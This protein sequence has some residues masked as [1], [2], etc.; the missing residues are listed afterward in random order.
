VFI[1]FEQA[2]FMNNG[3]ECG[4]SNFNRPTET[5][6]RQLVNAATGRLRLPLRVTDFRPPGRSVASARKADCA[7]NHGPRCPDDVLESLVNWNT[8]KQHM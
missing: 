3:N 2:R 4:L 6:L 5:L 8:C 1:I 7:G